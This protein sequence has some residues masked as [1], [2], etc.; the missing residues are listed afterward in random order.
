MNDSFENTV[1]LVS[2]NINGIRAAY[3]K[4][5]LDWLESAQPD[6]LALQE[7]KIQA[8]QMTPDMLEP[9]GAYNTYWA[10]A[11]RPGYSGV[12]LLSKKEPER[13]IIGLGDEKFD[14]EGRSIIAEYDNF[15]LFSH[16][17]PNGGQGDHRIQYKLEFYD[18]FLEKALEYKKEGWAV[19]ATGDFNTAHYPIDLARPKENENV[20]GF[21]PIER[22]WLDKFVEAGFVDTFRHV[23]GE[24][25]DR[26]S[27]WNMRTRA[28]ERNVGWRIDYFFVSDNAVD[29]IVD[30]DIHHDVMGSDHCPVT[31]TWKC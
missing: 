6:I 11:E 5:F 1:N 9:P 19:I 15:V 4:G 27:W 10:Y 20:T 14:C 23:K 22:A 24:V 29:R 26:Y 8:H 13:V 21:L 12:G 25:P 31:L 3:K 17:Y 18:Y 30:A 28:R 7:T 16:Y 2:W